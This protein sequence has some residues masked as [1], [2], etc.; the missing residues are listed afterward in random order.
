MSR[1]AGGGGPG[2]VSGPSAACSVAGAHVRNRVDA[3]WG[4]APAFLA[5]MDHGIF[6][7]ALDGRTDS[8]GCGRPGTQT[9][10]TVA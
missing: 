3:V 4:P 7:D 6:C 10:S 5:S 2:D 9:L 8:A 1:R